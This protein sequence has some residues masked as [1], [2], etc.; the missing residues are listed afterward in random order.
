MSLTKAHDNRG[1]SSYPSWLVSV[2]YTCQYSWCICSIRRGEQTPFSA[3]SLG[4]LLPVHEVGAFQTCLIMIT[5]GSF[6]LAWT[7]WTWIIRGLPCLHSRVSLVVP[8]RL[9]ALTILA[10]FL[11]LC[12]EEIS[13]S[14]LTWWSLDTPEFPCHLFSHITEVQ[15]KWPKL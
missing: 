15:T 11:I 8:Q 4:V 12:A 13:Q 7:D 9:R 10:P 5:Q 1:L 3:F 2:C 14:Y 6:E